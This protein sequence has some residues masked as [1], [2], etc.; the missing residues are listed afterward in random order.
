MSDFEKLKRDFFSEDS[1]LAW[2]THEKLAKIGG[3]K[4]IKFL[5]PLLKSKDGGIRN[6][7]GLALGQ[8][9]DKRA[10]EPLVKAIK[11]PKNRD[12]RGS[13]VHALADLDCSHLFLFMIELA[14]YGN[15]EVRSH[16]LI[17]LDKQ[18]FKITNKE[19]ETAKS[20]VMKY[21]ESERKSKDYEVLLDEIWEYIE[22]AEKRKKRK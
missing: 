16:A 6:C 8:I 15:F 12:N 1:D 11:N 19:I 22:K 21:A 5:I 9:G 4:V 14:L 13:L 20:M 10:I 2:E 17:I 18:T 3:E 7:A